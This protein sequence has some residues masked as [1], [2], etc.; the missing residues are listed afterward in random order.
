MLERNQLEIQQKLQAQME[1]DDHHAAGGGF[2]LH[3][4][5]ESVPVYFKS[6]RHGA[7]SCAEARNYHAAR[8]R[9]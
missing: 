2:L 1:K 6:N 7:G 9:I 5:C 8:Q 3:R 4:I